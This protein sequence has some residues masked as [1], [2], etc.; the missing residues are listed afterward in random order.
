VNDQ[1]PPAHVSDGETLAR[2]VMSERWVRENGSVRPDAF[3]P[4]PD[5]NLSVTRHL[6]L[7]TPRLWE[8]GANVAEERAKTLLGRAD[9]SAAAVRRTSPLEIVAARLDRNPEH[10]HIVGWP[11][12]KPRQKM[13]A[14]L[15]AASATYVAAPPS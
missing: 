15:L 7:S 11:T 13:L 9:V 10:A 12:E 2:F 5:L 14:Q 4:P 1:Q 6:A 8:R 3:V